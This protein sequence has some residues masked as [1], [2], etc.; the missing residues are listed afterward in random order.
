MAIAS[1]R[2]ITAQPQAARKTEESK[3][4]SFR[5]DNYESAF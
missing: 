4:L 5:A 2:E 3:L 1:Q